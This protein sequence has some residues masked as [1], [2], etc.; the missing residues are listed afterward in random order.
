MELNHVIAAAPEDAPVAERLAGMIRESGLAGA[1][2]CLPIEDETALDAELGQ[3]AD[4]T[5]DYV[6]LITRALSERVHSADAVDL[7]LGTLRLG[8]RRVLGACLSAERA[9]A[10]ELARLARRHDGL[11]AE[12]T[13]EETARRIVGRLARSQI[14]SPAL[15]AAGAGS[16]EARR[17]RLWLVVTIVA[18]VACLAALAYRNFRGR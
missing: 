3:D 2:R 6:L 13:L 11:A 7:L 17:L 18:L 10:P 12:P 15:P 8:R 4:G 16:P 5:T 9:P 14:N 1:V